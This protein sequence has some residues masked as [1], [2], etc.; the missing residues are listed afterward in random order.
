MPART[1]TS[2][3]GTAPLAVAAAFGPAADSDAVAMLAALRA[4]GAPLGEALGLA[5]VVHGDEALLPHV[6][7][8]LRTP[9]GRWLPNP[10]A[11]AV[12]VQVAP[13]APD[14]AAKGLCAW[15]RGRFLKGDLRLGGCTWVTALPEGVRV[16]G[17][18]DLGCT[19]LTALPEGFRVGG[20]LS[21]DESLIQTLPRGL[22]VR[23]DLSLWRCPDW[24]E[25]IPEGLEVGRSIC[26]ERHG[27]KHGGRVGEWRAATAAA[28]R[29][30]K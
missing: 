18:C 28:A 14:L 29:G 20:S 11:V 19:G 26:T 3:V 24:D 13:Y 16:E 8:A 21:L 30:G 27:F 22:S 25:G 6:V 15:G 5:A 7:E 9:T 2:N 4:T 12:L 23:L 17:H 10:Q 1:L